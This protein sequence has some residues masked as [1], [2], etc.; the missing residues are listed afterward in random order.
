MELL[1]TSVRVQRQV[2]MPLLGHSNPCAKQK[3][4]YATPKIQTKF[5]QMPPK[6]AKLAATP[7][8]RN[9]SLVSVAFTEPI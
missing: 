8:S 1:N 7:A 4:D 9:S 2:T 3:R 6:L 5:Q